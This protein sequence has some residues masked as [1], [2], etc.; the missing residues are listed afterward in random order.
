MRFLTA[1]RRRGQIVVR[2][3]A[4]DQAVHLRGAHRPPVET[5][6]VADCL[7]MICLSSFLFSPAVGLNARHTA[8][9]T[10]NATT[11]DASTQMYRCCMRTSAIDPDQNA[12][13]DDQHRSARKPQPDE[14]T[15]PKQQRREADAPERLGRDERRHDGHAPTV[16]RLEQADVRKAEA[17]ARRREDAE[18]AAAR[19]TPRVQPPATTVPVSSVAAAATVGGTALLPAMCLTRLSRAAKRTV[20]IAASASPPAR[21]CSGPPLGDQRDPAGDD[22]KRTDYEGRRDR[23]AEDDERDCD[24]NERRRADHDGSPRRADAADRE[25]EQKLRSTRREQARK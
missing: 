19:C 7:G 14:L 6:V 10:N 18:R 23:L 8:P 16:V 9:A 15:S 20:H 21:R 1:A 17:D 25:R 11:T 2:E 3:S 22:R 12:A 5:E 4:F 24:R 13:D